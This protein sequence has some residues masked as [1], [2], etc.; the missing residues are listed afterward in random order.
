MKNEDYKFHN[1]DYKSS[2]EVKF[3]IY[4]AIQLQEDL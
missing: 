1:W 2:S 3:A 4:D